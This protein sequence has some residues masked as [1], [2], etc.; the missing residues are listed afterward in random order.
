[1]PQGHPGC[2]LYLL[3]ECLLWRPQ[4]QSE[5]AGIL[6]SITS[7]SDEVQEVSSGHIDMNNDDPQTL[8]T[9]LQYIYG[10]SKFASE[11]GSLDPR[12]DYGD[13]VQ[14]CVHYNRL[15]A[16]ADKYRMDDLMTVWETCITHFFYYLGDHLYPEDETGDEAMVAF[17]DAIKLIYEVRS[18]L[19]TDLTQSRARLTRAVMEVCAPRREM[20]MNKSHIFRDYLK[21]NPGFAIDLLEQCSIMGKDECCCEFCAAIFY[22][23]RPEE[24]FEP[25]PECGRNNL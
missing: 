15:Y 4:G 7:I 17:I 8:D 3:R 5:A 22:K 2:P 6:L 25:C 18:E 14:Q 12:G 13:H 1:M 19:L 24:K 16:L 9:L 23:R 11:E 21:E 10:P 20:L